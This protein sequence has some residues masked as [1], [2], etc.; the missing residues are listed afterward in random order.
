MSAESLKQLK[1][2]YRRF[3]YATKTGNNER[4]E[5]LVQEEEDIIRSLMPSERYDY[6]MKEA[7]KLFGGNSAEMD[8]EIEEAANSTD[9]GIKAGYLDGYISAFMEFTEAM[10]SKH[11]VSLNESNEHIDETLA[12]INEGRNTASADTSEPTL[13]P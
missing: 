10:L 12:K 9:P 1:N 5:E 3:A 4:I 13:A 2:L 8:A 6:M 7:I 11:V